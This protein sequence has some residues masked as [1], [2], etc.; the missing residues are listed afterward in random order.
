MLGGGPNALR[1]ICRSSCSL[2]TDSLRHLPDRSQ[3][4]TK[5]LHIATSTPKR[6]LVKAHGIREFSQVARGDG[7][8]RREAG[9][10]R[11]QAGSYVSPTV[12]M[13]L[14]PRPNIEV[15]VSQVFHH[16]PGHVTSEPSRITKP[17][18][19]FLFR[20]PEQYV[21]DIILSRSSF[22]PR[23]IIGSPSSR[24][25]P[26]RP[27]GLGQFTAR[28]DKCPLHRFPSLAPGL[29]IHD[30]RRQRHTGPLSML[31]EG[32]HQRENMLNLRRGVPSEFV[33][34]CRARH[35]S[36]GA[37]PFG[38]H[39]QLGHRRITSPKSHLLQPYREF[40]DR[41]S[42]RICRPGHAS[43]SIRN[44]PEISGRALASLCLRLHRRCRTMPDPTEKIAEY[45]RGVT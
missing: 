33:L 24:Q 44:R 43:T 45:P 29:L 19:E 18:V 40:A 31:N 10:L 39:L 17:P 16:I 3:T 37:L 21:D 2:R 1:G 9:I 11:S 27:R 28:F 6:V 7:A 15:L 20:L 32:F 13:A 35:R 22:A 5:P 4:S 8:P 42:G 14:N 30:I 38:Q 26:Y 36:P 23:F 34:D 25:F 12:R 41:P